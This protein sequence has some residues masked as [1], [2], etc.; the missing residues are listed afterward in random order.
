MLINE[1][2]AVEQM[3]GKLDAATPMDELVKRYGH[4][5]VR[6]AVAQNHIVQWSG[7]LLEGYKNSRDGKTMCWLTDK[8]RESAA[9][10]LNVAAS[11]QNYTP[12]GAMP[13]F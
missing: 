5:A 8:G 10:S 1:L 4:K 9:L 12:A 3:M 6:E 7:A 2:Y 11:A 13:S